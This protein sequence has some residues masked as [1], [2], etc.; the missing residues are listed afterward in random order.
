MTS[1]SRRQALKLGALAGSSLLLP[2][3]FQSRSYA[4]TAGSPSVTPFTLPFRV[5]P[6]LNPVR[7]D[8]TTDYYEITMKKALVEILPKL[9]TEVWAYNGITPGPT[10]KQNKDRRS[11]VRFINNSVGTPTSVHLHGMASL[12]QYD[13]YAED[14]TNPGQYKDY[15][16]PNNR[17]AT[18]WYHDHA[19][20]KTARNVYMGLAGTYLVQDQEE[21]NLPLPKGDYDVPL[22][23]QDKQ[24]GSKG[25]LIFDDQG[26]K[27]QMGDIILVNGVPWPKMQVAN[28]K[29]RFRILNGSI[30]RSYQLALSTG[31][32]LI[33][34][35]TDAGLISAPVPTS[36]MRIG[37]AER[38]E[39][40]ID[41]SKYAVGT[42]IVLR[43]L[44]PPN[45]DNYDNTEKIMQFEVVRTE[46]DPSSIPSTLR[47]V[48]PIDEASAVRTREFRYER[49]NGLWVINGKIWDNQRFDA[50]PQL[51]DVEIWKIYNN[52]G[53]WFHPIHMHLLD[54][55]LLD[56]NG[57]PPFAYEKGWK[58]VFYV[59][60]N[61][62]LRV[63]GRFGPN[64]GTY[65]SHCH[66]TV[67]EDHDMMNQFKV[68]EATVNLASLAPAQ[69][70]PAPPL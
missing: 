46:S 64:S 33:V 5:P 41:F 8:S 59:G 38:Y 21:L 56:R 15:I 30:S 9:K 28:R 43:N 49:S 11:V 24:F 7:S 1:I 14:L 53:G 36:S 10:I 50:S 4:G 17:A 47:Y 63:I 57:K 20:H 58:D 16:Y 51:G 19:I 25:N 6:V 26:Q 52:A 37:M 66:N 42:K 61:E 29:Y 62:T 27:S 70:L 60:E 12:P 32:P 67:H 44:Q 40:I 34:I 69:S 23:I 3:A 31:E 55:Q 35:G 13:G 45:N 39:V 54:M 65:M 68:G 2:I 18:L 48:Q 22:L